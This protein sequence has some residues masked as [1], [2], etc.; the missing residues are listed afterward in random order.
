RSALLSD[1]DAP[2]MSAVLASLLLPAAP[3]ASRQ[4]H[5][6][7]LRHSRPRD[8]MVRGCLLLRLGAFSDAYCAPQV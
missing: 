1:D 7:P 8:W 5:D 4:Q 2:E 6:G 3:G